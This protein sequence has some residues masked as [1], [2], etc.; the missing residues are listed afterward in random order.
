[1]NWN[2]ISALV[3]V[4]QRDEASAKLYSA[5]MAA[6]CESQGLPKEAPVEEPR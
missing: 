1:M 4:Q 2:D 6:A 5:I 3:Q